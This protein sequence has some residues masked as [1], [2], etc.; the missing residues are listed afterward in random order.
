MIAIKFSVRGRD[1]GSAVDEAKETTSDLVQPPYRAEWSGEFQ[2][3]EEAE[4]PADDHRPG[5]RWR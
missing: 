4:A 5:C 3:M 1:L 2:E